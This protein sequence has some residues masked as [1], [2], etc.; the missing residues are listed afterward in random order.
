MES[1]PSKLLS[2]SGNGPV[3]VPGLGRLASVLQDGFRIPKLPVLSIRP[4]HI[5]ASREA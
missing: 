2:F 4:V 1:H 5:L 3:F